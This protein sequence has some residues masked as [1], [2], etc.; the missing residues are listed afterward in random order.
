MIRND[1]IAK[2]GNLFISNFHPLY[3]LIGMSGEYTVSL[4][5][6]YFVFPCS[7][8]IQNF[9]NTIKLKY[10]IDDQILDGS[11]GSIRKLIN[12]FKDTQN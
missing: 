12:F 1:A 8:T 4:L 3:V 11:I 5:H 6:Q 9:R 10:K 7:K 2:Y